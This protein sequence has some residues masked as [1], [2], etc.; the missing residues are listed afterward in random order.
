MTSVR[1]TTNAPSNRIIRTAR[2]IAAVLAFCVPTTAQGQGTIDS[3][4]L[5]LSRHYG[6]PN[7]VCRLAVTASKNGGQ[8]SLIWG[9]RRTPWGRLP[10]HLWRML[11]RGNALGANTGGES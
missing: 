6:Y 4:A 2:T 9:S 3:V 1:R 11:R 7:G 5:T 8:A 10:A